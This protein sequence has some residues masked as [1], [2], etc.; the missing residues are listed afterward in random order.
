MATMRRRIITMAAALLMFSAVRAADA[1]LEDHGTWLQD[2]LASA[3][4]G[5]TIDVPPGEHTGPFV[6]ATTVHLRGRGQAVLRGDG[7]THVLAIRAPDVVIEGLDIRGSGLELSADHAAIHITA[8]RAVIRGNRI[9]ESLHGVYV[10]GVNGVRVEGNTVIGK[11]RTMELVDPLA[12]ST[13]P[14]G[15][16]MCEVDL[17]QDRRGNGL[18]FWNSSGHTITGNVV[19]DTR[20]G[21]YFSFVDDTTVRGNDIARVRYGLHYM[22]SDGNRF[23]GNV[24]RD[25][26][27]GA[28]LMYSKGIVLQDNEFSANRSQRSHGLLMHSVDDTEVRGNRLTGNTMGMFLENGHANR[29]L[30]NLVIGNHVGLHITDSSHDNVFSGNAFAGNLHAVETDGR[31]VA[32]A[33]ALDGV[34]NFWQGANPMDLDGDGIGDLPHREL[35]LFG[36]LRRPFPVIGL[37][38]GSP[39]ERLLHFVHSRL[40]LPG[41]SG[42]TDPAPLVKAGIR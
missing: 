30:N 27:A 13:A 8:A 22:Y 34:G 20:D 9:S 10:R 25:N 21:I 41:V 12:G 26:A 29:I 14:G 39:G 31:N 32:N 42:I 2:R 35:D 15:G 37:L 11:T 17:G 40:A 3:R 16:E 19:R 18:H 7:H 33:F 1:P 5:E 36:D 24:F 6:I 23:D 38:A 4:P 28:A